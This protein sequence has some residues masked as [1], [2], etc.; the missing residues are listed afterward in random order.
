MDEHDE[1]DSAPGS[2]SLNSP[3]TPQTQQQQTPH[4]PA[5]SPK[6][7]LRQ[8]STP[9]SASPSLPKKHVAS[10]YVSNQPVNIVKGTG[11]RPS[12]PIKQPGSQPS[13]RVSSPLKWTPAPGKNEHLETTPTGFRYTIELPESKIVPTKN[14]SA[15][16]N[17]APITPVKSSPVT[18][19]S[20][21][22]SSSRRRVGS[23][24]KSQL[25][26]PYK[27]V[28]T[29]WSQKDTL[30][31]SIASSLTFVIHNGPNEKRSL[32]YWLT[33]YSGV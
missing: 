15:T 33:F 23:P 12:S 16:P 31:F 6:Q 8:Q 10:K 14:S 26:S 29:T 2:G 27:E 30:K 13:S 1:K 22:H 5:K 32:H 21:K 4:S 7:F 24:S 18:P 9:T 28:C 20:K 3:A 17:K 19:A 25:Q 11:S